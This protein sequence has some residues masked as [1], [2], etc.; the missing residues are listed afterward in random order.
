MSGKIYTRTGDAGETGLFG[1]GRVA[2]NHPRVAAYGAVDELN[3][4]LGQVL[5]AGAA[6]AL[7]ERLERLQGD[8]LALGAE[9][10]TPR[11]SGA[12]RHAHI[13]P[14]PVERIAEMEAWMDEADRTLP[15]LTSFILPGGAP[16]GA[17]LHVARTVCRRA[18]R[19][20]VQLAG[21]T[22]VDGDAIRFLNRLSD[23]LFV[24]ARLANAEAGRAETQWSGRRP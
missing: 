2:K 22:H 1:G 10:A 4:V 18:E 6:G 15:Q 7:G 12:P 11:A 9:L 19:E 16:V 17:A 24:A 23:Y 3:A 14:L 20:V 13:P 21:S 5:A 8:L